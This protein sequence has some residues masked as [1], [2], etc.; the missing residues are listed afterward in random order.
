MWGQ[1]FTGNTGETSQEATEDHYLHYMSSHL[2]LL[3]EKNGETPQKSAQTSQ[4]PSNATIG[5][6]EPAGTMALSCFCEWGHRAWKTW[7]SWLPAASG[8]SRTKTEINT[9]FFTLRLQTMKGFESTGDSHGNGFGVATIMCTWDFKECTTTMNIRKSLVCEISHIHW[10]CYYLP[11]TV[12]WGEVC[13][14][15]TIYLRKISFLKM[16]CSMCLQSKFRTS[17][18]IQSALNCFQRLITVRWKSRN[19]IRHEMQERLQKGSRICAPQ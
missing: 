16:H 4:W 13:N 7:G 19:L 11:L 5:A 15:I 1:I 10:G 2:W 6:G 17:K 14:Q 3:P 9:S 18:K 12:L 8:S